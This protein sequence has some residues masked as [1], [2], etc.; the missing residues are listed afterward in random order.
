MAYVH[1]SAS[2]APEIPVL[3]HGYEYIVCSNAYNA[4]VGRYGSAQRPASVLRSQL[5]VKASSEC[6]VVY[7]PTANKPG[8]R[9]SP[10]LATEVKATRLTTARLD[11]GM[12][13]YE[14]MMR[15]RPE[16]RMFEK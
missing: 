1:H 5:D 8:P 14:Q 2:C 7:L 6:R 11:E 4:S 12:K 16:A 3:D 9:S 10:V 13:A 15:F